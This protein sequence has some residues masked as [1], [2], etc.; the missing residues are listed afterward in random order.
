MKK[1]ILCDIDGCLFD[2]SKIW[3][4]INLLFIP[5]FEPERKW[6]YFEERANDISYS[7]VNPII[8][9]QLDLFARMGYKIIFST[10]RSEKIRIGTENR[11]NMEVS[12]PYELLMRPI[13]N[14]FPAWKLK[15]LHY[16]VM[17]N[18]YDIKLAIDD[19]YDNLVMY[20]N[21]GVFTLAVCT[22]RLF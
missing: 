14:T 6:N 18:R 1:A 16:E 17:K 20:A 5:D 3:A 11:I 10:A 7:R 13:N 22:P 9:E 12:F 15:K 8:A 21:E 2:T 4:E 19:E